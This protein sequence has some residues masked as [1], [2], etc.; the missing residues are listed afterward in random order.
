MLC[1][2]EEFGLSHQ[3]RPFA[4]VARSATRRAGLRI[5]FAARLRQYEEIL[6]T[7]RAV[8]LQGESGRFERE[9]AEPQATRAPSAL[10]K[11][12]PIPGL[13]LVVS[14]EA[15]KRVGSDAMPWG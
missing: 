14:V 8:E 5:V 6:A 1:Q 13:R 11:L 15:L 2:L 12:S 10:S 9:D 3:P 4:A 7:S